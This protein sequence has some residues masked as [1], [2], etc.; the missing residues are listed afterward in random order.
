M[1]RYIVYGAGGIGG[2]IGAQL[3]RAGRRVTL[4]ARGSHLEAMRS[5]GLTVETPE[6]SE[7][8]AVDAVGH[9]AELEV[10]DGDVVLLTMK[11]QDTQ[12]ALETLHALAGSGVP[13]VC[14]QNG[15][16]NERM[17][18]RRFSRV[19]GMLVYMPATFLEPGRVQLN[20]TPIRGV[21]DAG[22]YP[23]G[24]D[25]LIEAV[26]ADLETAGFSARPDPQI[27]RS[28]YGKLLMNLGNAV[29]ALCGIDAD[30][31]AVTKAVRR[32]GHAC[33]TAAGIDYL[34]PRELVTRRDRGMR[35][36]PIDGSER[37]GGSTW[38]SLMRGSSSVESDFLNGEIALLGTLYD[39]PTPY[40]RAVQELAA[41]AAR[42][43]ASPGAVSVDEIVARAEAG[44]DPES[45]R[46]PLP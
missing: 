1:M 32:E 15:V 33:L 5:R 11:S 18:A 44:Y 14:A 17:A 4:I 30:T 26:C 36:A 8:L 25:P 9:P 10:G 16:A 28:K 43:R 7:T 40:N 45:V 29:Q 31:G 13:V 3:H 38:Q 34:P 46:P 39:V 37:K 41:R 2:G 20:G 24:V 42:E 22:R 35:M 27:M 21:L 6:G 23:R 12:P 19:Y